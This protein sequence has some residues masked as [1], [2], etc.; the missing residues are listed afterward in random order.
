MHQF[1]LECAIAEFA[2]GT[3]SIQDYYV[4][5]RTLWL[6][7]DSIKYA[8]GADN[9]LTVIQD[10]HASSQRDQFFMKLRTEYENVQSALMNRMPLP[11]LDVCLNELLHE[12]QRIATS[13]HIA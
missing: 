7:Y 2:Q 4:G 3:L 12:E 11:S 9:I 5:F 13:A 10:L 1:H 8:D 6:E